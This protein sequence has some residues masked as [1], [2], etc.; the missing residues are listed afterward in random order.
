MCTQPCF[1]SLLY[2]PNAQKVKM[3]MKSSS[4]RSSRLCAAPVVVPVVLWSLI[5]FRFARESLSLW[6]HYLYNKYILFVI[7]GYL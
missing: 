3:V 1:F 2:K 7:F 6:R 5:L 4:M